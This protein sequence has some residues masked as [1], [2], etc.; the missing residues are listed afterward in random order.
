MTSGLNEANFGGR[1]FDDIVVSTRAQIPD[2]D[3]LFADDFTRPAGR[4]GDR[5]LSVGT[6]TD[7]RPGGL[8]SAT[9]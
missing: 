1:C 5:R 9:G 2:R 8:P 4:K 6:P 7:H 3:V